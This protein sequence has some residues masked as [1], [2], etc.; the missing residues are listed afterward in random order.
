[1]IFPLPE[2]TEDFVA[3]WQ[4]KVARAT[5]I[6][7]RACAEEGPRARRKQNVAFGIVWHLMRLR[8]AIAGQ[9]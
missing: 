6:M 1:M 2:P 5:E 4:R 7:D 3:R 9:R 8:D